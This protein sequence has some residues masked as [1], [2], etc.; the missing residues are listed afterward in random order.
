MANLIEE[1]RRQIEAE[2]EVQELCTGIFDS[3]K[4]LLEEK[5]ED[6]FMNRFPINPLL[7]DFLFITYGSL[8][9]D[10]LVINRV[11]NH[12][13]HVGKQEVIVKI[14]AGHNLEKA[15]K[16][17]IQIQG[18]GVLEVTKRGLK[19]KEKFEAIDWGKDGIPNILYLGA[20]KLDGSRRFDRERLNGYYD[21]I[22]TLS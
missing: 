4:H 18:S 10:N 6:F 15:R 2:K 14:W 16:M 5:G 11:F 19:G 8:F 7:R 9:M 3:A 17:S 12:I 22:K 13:E 1:G 20:Q 21:A